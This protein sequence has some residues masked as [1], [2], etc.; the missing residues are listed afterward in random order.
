MACVPTAPST[1]SNCS[2]EERGYQRIRVRQDTEANWLKNDPILASGEFGYV[3][4]STDP[5]RMLKIGDGWV[6]WSQLPWLEFG[7]GDSDQHI[8][9]NTK[10]PPGE[11]VG[12]LWIC[13]DPDVA[14]KAFSHANPPRYLHPLLPAPQAAQGFVAA[15]PVTVGGKRLLLPLME[16]VGVSPS[17]YQP[18]LLH[19]SDQPV[20]TKEDGS[21]IQGTPIAGGIYA[22]VGGKRYILPVLES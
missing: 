17:K 9:S 11:D 6:K 7:A 21:S 22:I 5:A 20:T 12:D 15:V 14:P 10:P 3:I 18:S 1:H 2:S 4:G 13:P 19:Y 16:V 8:V